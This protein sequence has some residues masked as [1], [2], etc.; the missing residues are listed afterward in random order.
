[1]PFQKKLGV[2]GLVAFLCAGASLAQSWG[3]GASVGITDDVTHLS[4][5]F[6]PEFDLEPEDTVRAVF[7]GLGS[8][9]T[10]RI[11][12]GRVILL[13]QQGDVRAPWCARQTQS[14]SVP[15]S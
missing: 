13:S 4:L 8:D 2:A 9:G 3:V 14:S 10:V 12:G 15:S 7:Y 11:R 5:P 1:M 6:D